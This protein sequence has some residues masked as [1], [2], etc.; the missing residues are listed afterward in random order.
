MWIKWANEYSLIVTAS[1]I[2]EQKDDG[3]FPACHKHKVLT[4]EE[5]HWH[6]TVLHFEILVGLLGPV[7]LLNSHRSTVIGVLEDFMSYA[8]QMAVTHPWSV[9]L[10]V[11]WSFR[12]FQDYS[13]TASFCLNCTSWSDRLLILRFLL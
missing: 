9:L 11:E 4:E 13:L 2:F 12:T 6:R 1:Q 10:G 5:F 7:P 8:R 3:G